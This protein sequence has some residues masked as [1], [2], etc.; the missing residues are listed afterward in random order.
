MTR[1]AF[2]RGPRPGWAAALALLAAGCGDL[3][4]RYRQP[5]Q[6]L[7]PLA[8]STSVAYVEKASAT[9]LVIDPADPQL[10]PRLV[11]VG[12]NPVLAARRTGHDE[13]LVLSQGVRDEAGAKP[14][15]ASLA[16]I[17]GDRAR[18]ARTFKL[19]SRFN[20]LAQSEPDGRFLVLTFTQAGGAARSGDVLFNPNEIAVIDLDAPGETAPKSRT[21]RSFGGVPL[22]VAFSPPLTLPGE[23]RTLRLGVILSDGYVTL[24]DLEHGERVEITVPLA[25]PEDKRMLRPAQVLFDQKDP[26][27]DPTVFVRAD[28]SNDIFA[29]RLGAVPAA[30]RTDRGNDFRP[31]LSLLAAGVRP[32]DMALFDGDGGSRLLVVSPGSSEALVLDARTS[33]STSIR[34]D[35]PASRILRF[36]S[37][38]PAEP[39]VK[40]RALLLALGGA[41]QVAGFLDLDRLEEL[42]TRNLETRPMGAVATGVVPFVDRGLVV[43]QHEAGAGGSGLSV[44]DL[45]RRTI[46]PLVTD[47]I[48]QV[49]IGPPAT[50]RLWVVPAGSARLGFLSISQLQPGEVRLD[51]PVR[52]VLALDPDRNGRTWVVV[53]H[54]HPGGSLTVLDAAR[55]ERATARSSIGFLYTHLLDRDVP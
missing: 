27:Q 44:I 41:V 26:A 19:G 11:P 42:R 5:W 18:P 12:K 51:A 49:V 25:P 34:L 23:G 15:E 29:L 21:L 14:E 24:F 38:S 6:P 55:P 33:R 8:L 36:E 54:Q 30:E 16:V 43:V 10:E 20:T 4:Q 13:L 17:A 52:S 53:D 7:P 3:D 50:D 1:L 9:A 2:V 32:S 48:A 22:A 35:A 28:G 45:A 31:V 37:P 40:P 39:K 46:S 47:R